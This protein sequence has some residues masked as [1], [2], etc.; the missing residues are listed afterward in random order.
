MNRKLD[1]SSLLLITAILFGAIIRFY[2]A[3]TNQFPLND[4]GMF[5]SMVQ[6]IKTNGYA[7]PQFT[8]YNQSDIPFAYPPLGFYIIASLSDL[9]PVSEL[10]L[11]L[12]LPAFVNTFSIIAF[13][14]LAKEILKDRLPASLATIFY[15]LSAR[16]FL[17]QIMGGG[18]TRAFGM[19][20]LLLMLWQLTQL[21]KNYQYKHLILTILFGAGAI[22]SHPQTALH[23]ALGGFLIFLFFGIHK[24][25]FISAILVGLGVALLSSP[26]WL[27]V[28][29]RHGIEPFISAGQ[30]SQRTT[31]SYLSLIQFTGLGDYLFIPTLILAFVGIYLLFKQ[32]NFF[33]ITWILLAYLI[34]PRGGDG[35]ALLPFAM[36]AGIGLLTL[37]EKLNNNQFSTPFTDKKVQLVLI[38]LILFLFMGSSIFDFQ[39]INTS[40][41]SKDL[42]TIKW[43]NENIGENKTFLLVT[44]Q[45][46]SMTDP[47][48]EWF[49]ALTNQYSR[50]TMQGLEW[51]LAENFFPYYEQL[52]LLQKCVDVNCVN[53][54][55]VRNNVEYDYIIILIPA[56]NDNGDL[57][58]SLRALGVSV[59]SSALHLLVYES[60]HALVLE[61]KK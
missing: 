47:L 49:P 13:Y 5:Y 43:I 6:N 56:Q 8:N 42:E 33:F 25:G 26:W 38:F 11:F 22:T 23:A 17:W 31:E 61:L 14:L 34:D 37:L 41:K 54:W 16:A 30:S 51:I 40:L 48:Q 29:S 28:L 7:L 59:R 58:D 9:L 18:I 57:V 12:Y 55:A 44:G 24:R 3:I 1:I 36:L 4:G 53:K 21:F 52:T 60:E 15:T 19:F 39:L 27:T 2:P 10:T 50:T 32:K 35:I 45:E 46:F 20:F